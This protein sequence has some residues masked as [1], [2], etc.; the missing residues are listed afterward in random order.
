MR[1]IGVLMAPGRGRSAIAGPRCRVRAGASAKEERVSVGRC[2]YNRLSTDIVAST[3][4]VLDDDWLAEP[5]RQPLTRQARENVGRAGRGD[6]RDQTDRPRRI[7]FCPGE[8]PCD[9]QG[10]SVRNQMQKLS[11]E[12]V[13]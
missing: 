7:G 5:L 8:T 12:E 6:W 11:A 3:R 1:R 10:G 4:S 13:S 9:W 2:T